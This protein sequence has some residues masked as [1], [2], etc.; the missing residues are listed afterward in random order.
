[1]RYH[2]LLFVSA[3]F[4][5][6]IRDKQNYKKMHTRTFLV[7]PNQCCTIA[8]LLLLCGP[9]RCVTANGEQRVSVAHQSGPIPIQLTGLQI[10]RLQSTQSK[11]NT[12]HACHIPQVLFW[13]PCLVDCASAMA[14]TIKVARHQHLCTTNACKMH[15]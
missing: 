13:V 11:V 1:M 12:L 9:P 10:E 7:D 3:L 15:T 2:P 8:D 6:L 5:Y 4:S 14:N